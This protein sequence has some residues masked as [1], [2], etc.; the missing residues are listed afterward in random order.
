MGLGERRVMEGKGKGREMGGEGLK[1]FVL[2]LM[3]VDLG[4]EI[5]LAE[6]GSCLNCFRDMVQKGWGNYNCRANV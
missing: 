1:L 3:F 2:F 4:K 5:A 6:T